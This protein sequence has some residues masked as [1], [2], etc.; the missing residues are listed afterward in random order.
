MIACQ[1][2]KTARIN[3]QSLVQTKL[4]GEICNGTRDQF[5]IILGRPGVLLIHVRIES[6][7]HTIV[8]CKIFP[9]FYRKIPTRLIHLAQEPNRVVTEPLPQGIVKAAKE[10]RR[11]RLPCPP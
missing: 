5:W 3:W 10:T 4:H 9:A 11:F 1:Y 8:E 7:K 2:A 6:G